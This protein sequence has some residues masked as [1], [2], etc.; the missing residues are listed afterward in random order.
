MLSFDVTFVESKNNSQV[1]GDLRRHVPYVTSLLFD[2]HVFTQYRHIVERSYEIISSYMSI[3]IQHCVRCNRLGYFGNTAIQSAVDSPHKRPLILCLDVFFVVSLS[4]LS[5]QQSIC[6]C[7]ITSS[8]VIFY[9]FSL[10]FKFQ[11]QILKF[12]R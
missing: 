4:K 6:W 1:S 8:R 11:P 9:I 2:I 3:G 12:Q 7:S 10:K 5:K